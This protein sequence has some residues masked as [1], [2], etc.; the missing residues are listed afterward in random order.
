MP[1]I[2][3]AGGCFWGLEKYIRS[4]KGV[5]SAEVGYANGMTDNPSYED[6]CYNDTGHAETVKVEYDAK[7]LP[8]HFLL[9]LYFNAV[10]PTSVNLRAATGVCSTEPA[11]ITRTRATCLLSAARLKTCKS[12][13]TSRLR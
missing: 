7:V 6:V 8:L 13:L 11:Y 12:A 4:I 10:D 5:L 9:E 2:Y 3:L 1:E